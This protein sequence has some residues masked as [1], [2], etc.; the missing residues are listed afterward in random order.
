MR[1]Q[2][3]WVVCLMMGVAGFFVAAW[4]AMNPL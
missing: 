4:V 3:I 2:P 1:M